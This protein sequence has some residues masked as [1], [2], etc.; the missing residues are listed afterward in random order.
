[1]GSLYEGE[2][3][4]SWQQIGILFWVGEEETTTNI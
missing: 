2:K 3:K 1:M 4:T